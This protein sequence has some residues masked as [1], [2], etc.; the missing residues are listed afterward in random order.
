MLRT[1]Q[2]ATVDLADATWLGQW[3][4]GGA[5]GCS[6]FAAMVNLGNTH[7]CAAVM[8][9]ATRQIVFYDP[10]APV[11]LD[12]QTEFSLGRLRLLGSCFLATQ[13]GD[14]GASVAAMGWATRHVGLPH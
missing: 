5:V 2:G 14:S 6:S 12:A 3:W 4:A 8:H 10:L 11:A 9:L 7:W 1:P 13:L